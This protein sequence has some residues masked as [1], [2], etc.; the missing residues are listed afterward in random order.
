MPVLL[1]LLS[2]QI[3][4]T[5]G[6]APT[7]RTLVLAA[8]EIQRND[9]FDPDEA[10]GW[11]PRLANALHIRTREGVVRREVLLAPGLPFDSARAEETARHL[12]GLGIFRRVQVDTVSTDSGLVVRVLTRDAWGNKLDF[13]FYRS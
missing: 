12:R 5:S 11:L 9:I 1:R 10:R 2:I 3:A 4:A 6:A 8:V 13:G 7:P